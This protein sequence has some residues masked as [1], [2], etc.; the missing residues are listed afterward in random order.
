MSQWHEFDVLE[1]SLAWRED[2]QCNHGVVLV[3]E[4]T[5]KKVKTIEECGF[6]DFN[7]NVEFKP[8]LVSF[9]QSGVEEEIF[10]EQLPR[11]ALEWKMYLH[12]RLRRSLD[13]NRF[14]PSDNYLSSLMGARQHSKKRV[15]ERCNIH[16]LYIGFRDLGWSE[17]ILAPDGYT[18][19]YCSGNCLFP[20][21]HDVNASSHAMIQS[22]VH[23]LSPAEIPQPCCAPSKLKLFKVLYT[24]E[25]NDVA[26]KK[27]KNMVV[28]QCGCQ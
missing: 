16:D 28:E 3:C 25:K 15:S 19:N 22:I 9:Y 8:F 23:L 7:G 12:D 4:T 24:N 1:G 18:A 2:P 11:S 5:D 20:L 10:A 26:M 17:W 6:V 27:M 14:I 21:G 13:L